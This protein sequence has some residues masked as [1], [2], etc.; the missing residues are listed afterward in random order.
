[1]SDALAPYTA[2][3]DVATVLAERGKNY[4]KFEDQAKI[5]FALA[6]AMRVP[7]WER[8]S[9]DQKH[10]LRI[11]SDKIARMLNGNPDYIDNW[12]DIAGYATLV[13][14]RLEGAK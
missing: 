6:D 14:R 4:G 12:V 1:M 5:A 2:T 13:V 7:G 9:V 8:L 10:A 3:T 11:I